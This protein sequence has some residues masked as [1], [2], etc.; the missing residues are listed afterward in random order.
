MPATK[1]IPRKK[2]PKP[3]GGGYFSTMVRTVRASNKGTIMEKWIKAL[4]RQR[5]VIE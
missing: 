2:I 5:K 1:S 3:A 4:E